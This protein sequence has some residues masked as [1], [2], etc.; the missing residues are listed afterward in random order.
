MKTEDSTAP[1]KQAEEVSLSDALETSY[2]EM[3]ADDDRNEDEHFEDNSIEEHEDAQVEVSAEGAQEDDPG[4][5]AEGAEADQVVEAAAEITDFNE[6]APERWPDEYKDYYNKLDAQG[7]EIFLDKM[8]KPM[9]RKFTDA[10]QDLAA[11]RK[12]LDPM[13]QT[14]QQHSQT[15]Q[16]AG[17]NPVEAFNRQMAWASHFA[18]VG[19]VKGAQD[20]AKAYGQAAGQHEEQGS[21]EQAYMTPVEKAQQARLDKLEANQQSLVQQ[22]QQRQQRQQQSIQ[23]Q[24][25]QTVMQSID[26]FANEAR[27]G[28]PVHPHMERVR[29]QMAGL[30]RGGLVERVDE[31][32]QPVPFNQQLGQAYQLACE[33]DPSIRQARDTRTRKQQVAKVSAANREVVSKTSGNDTV[34][35]ER[36][37]SDS[38]N[39]L[40]DRLDR[41]AA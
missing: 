8:F 29:G 12:A 41:S 15:F 3:S 30:I 35:D 37:L 20:L 9:Q 7:K 13:M 10:T 22:D 24:R 11:Q 4:Q 14:L 25:Q 17:I 26:A 28:Q 18:E 34:V 36:P 21:A 5:Q 39:D 33:M 31:Y 32:G 23:Q 19:P 40:Y 2:D 16:Q 27:D 38:L 6:A 1:E